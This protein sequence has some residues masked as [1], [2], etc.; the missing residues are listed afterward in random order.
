MRGERK[1]SI[2]RVKAFYGNFGVL[3]RALAYI[4]AHG[5]PGLRNATVDA[6]LNAARALLAGKGGGQERPPHPEAAHA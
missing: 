2:G 4:L 3:V 6:V 5:G 1:Q